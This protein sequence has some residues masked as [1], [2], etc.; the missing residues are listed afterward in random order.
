MS[1]L[2]RKERSW[3]KDVMSQGIELGTPRTEGHA[4][5]NC[6]TFA[7]N[8]TRTSVTIREN[9]A[10]LLDPS[11]PVE[12]FHWNDPKSRLDLI[13]PMK[14]PEILTVVI[15]HWEL[16]NTIP[17]PL[18][19]LLLA[20]FA[21]HQPCSRGP[22]FFSFNFRGKKGEEPE[23]VVVTHLCWRHRQNSTLRALSPPRLKKAHLPWPYY[24]ARYQVTIQWR[25][26]HSN[27]GNETTLADSTLAFLEETFAREK[28]G[29]RR[30]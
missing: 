22:H 7:R 19:P 29:L 12:P 1:K 5:T 24:A 9:K 8:G 21:N 27:D 16:D 6:A 14:F 28:K 17:P 30:V 26:C 4:L 13:F 2:H 11:L 18:A 25:A 20:K 10:T 23:N 3:H 15:N